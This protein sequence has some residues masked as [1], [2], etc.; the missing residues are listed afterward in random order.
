MP[1]PANPT[2][3]IP[4]LLLPL[5]WVYYRRI[6]RSFGPQPWQP[7]RTLLRLVVL[8]AA[9]L[10]LAATVVPRSGLALA[11]GGA[12]GLLLG[13]IGVR[14]TH[15]EWRAGVRTYIPNPW[16]GG[17]LTLVLL[18]RLAWRYL[19]GGGLQAAGQ[20]SALTLGLGLAA[21]LVAYGLAYSIGL[22]RR[23]AAL[24]AHPPAV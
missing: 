4:Y 13:W 21:A 12:A 1:L 18:G 15:A 22:L 24:G 19:H 6:R 5:G 17:V 3:W 2:P 11:G 10:G 9:M 20:P 8:V 16:I 7:R 14:H 23:M